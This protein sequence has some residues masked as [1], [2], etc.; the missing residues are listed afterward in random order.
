[1]RKTSPTSRAALRAGWPLLLP[2][3]GFSVLVNLLMLTGPL[4]MLQIYDR[5]LSS[6]SEATL[7]ALFLL[8]G[9]LYSLMAVLDYARGRVLARYGGR[10]Q[11]R[12]DGD[13]FNATMR[14]A[15]FAQDRASPA[16]ELRDVE[17][18]H[19]IFASPVMLALFDL[20]WTPVFV[21]AI[22]IFHPLLGWLAV[23]GGLILVVIAVL[24]AVLTQRR[25][26]EAQ[27][28]AQ[29]G[30]TFAEHAR[31]GSELVH[32]QG[33]SGVI[34]NRWLALRSE[35]LQQSLLANDQSGI[36]TATT[37]AFRLFLQSAMLALG[38]WLVLQG[39][40]TAGAMIAGSILLGRALGP[41]EQVVGQWSMIQRAR[42]SWRRIGVLLDQVEV[43]PET[44]E[45]PRPK[46]ELKVDKAFVYVPDAKQPTIS[47]ISLEVL[48]G[49]A[50]G[51]IGKSGSGK[52]TLVKTMLGL[53]KPRSGEVRLGGATLDQ[54]EIDALGGFIGYLPQQVFLFSGTVVENIARMSTAPDEAKV[55]EAAKRAN[56]HD[57]ILG[58]PEGYQ[59]IVHGV[60]N[61]LSG[62]QRQR[63]ALARALYDDPVLLIL[64]EPNSAL[65]S[66][67]TDALNATIKTFKA[68]GRAVIIATHRPLAIAECDTLAVIDAGKIAAFGPRE[69]VLGKMVQNGGS[70]NKRLQQRAPS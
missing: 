22:F 58:L 14:K 7:V 11:A 31:A 59:T 47:G 12:L 50:L 57:M 41:I 63:I 16:S 35:A 51:V 68:S 48:P 67:G 64:D 21:A 1:M 19:S 2:V 37:K 65:D 66:E 28:T 18:V 40:L 43:L 42:A 36:F 26:L 46:A 25:V 34:A 62:G 13:V 55:I 53:L 44:I 70:I 17:A 33:M 38:A 5:V 52:T 20:P 6:R 23:A 4:F 24:N 9:A 27:A 54:Y 39:E 10:F 15:L 56:A 45:L 60:E 8:V 32:A 49:T 61:Q 69:E 29:R 30:H 3:F